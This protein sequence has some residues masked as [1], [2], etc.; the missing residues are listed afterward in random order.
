MNNLQ[1]DQEFKELVPPLS[2]E[3][4][5]QLK[6]NIKNEGWRENEAILIWNNKIIDGHHRYKICQELGINNFKVSKKEFETRE[7]VKVW[8]INNQKG[9]RNLT[10]GWKWELA[11]IKK[12][13]LEERG[14]EKQLST[15]KKGEEKP[16]LSESDKT[17]KHN[18][19]EEIAQELGWSTGKVGV[20]EKVW[21]KAD[22]ETKEKIKE[23]EKSFN[24]T[25]EEIKK[26]EREQERLRK[27][28]QQ[29]KELE[30]NPPEEAKGKYDVIVIDPPW[31]YHDDS[32]YDANGFRGTTDYPTMTIEEIK[33]IELPASENCVL[34]LW[35]THKMMRHAFELLDKWGFEE[36]AILTW[37][38]N[39]M[40]IGRW[41]RS[42]SEFCIMAVKGKPTINLTNQTTVLYAPIG[43]HSE[44]PK[45]FYDMVDEL[46]IGR[47]LDYFARKTREGWDV[48]GDEVNKKEGEDDT[49]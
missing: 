17:E 27:I 10:D 28:E 22:E 6:A 42:K 9:R 13:I 34:W 49:N 2:T 5:E 40:G 19:R 15:L 3:E 41:L 12:K 14:R 26:R 43:K 16:V 25:Y 48:Y 33:N 11:R 37:C 47:K 35:T 7:E 4:Y 31:K 39:K 46:C 29:K 32:V 8:M 1:I 38:K 36:K 45:E 18:T 44:K 23:G 30:E 21:N 24:E 20:A